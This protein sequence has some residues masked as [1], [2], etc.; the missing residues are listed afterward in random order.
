MKTLLQLRPLLITIGMFLG[1]TT[2]IA[3]Q[4]V[5]NGQLIDAETKESV[6]GATVV[7]KGSTIG[8]TTDF[9]GNFKLE[10]KE[11]G[12][13]VILF[14]Y[15]GYQTIEQD[16]E[17]GG[18]TDLGVIELL[19]DA[20]NLK[21]VNVIASVAVD[22]QTPVAVSTV[23][24]EIIEEK[25][26]NQEFPEVLKSSPGVFTTKQGGGFG[27]SRIT[28]R[29]FG[30]ENIAV[31]INGM[32]INDMENGAVYWSNWAGL[33]DVTRNMQVQRGL[34]ATKLAIPSVGG[35]INILTRTTDA[36]LG[37]NIMVAGGNNNYK[38]TSFT[39]STGLTEKKWAVTL[40]GSQSSGDGW[41]DGTNFEAYSYFANISK[42]FNANHS[43]ALSIFG[44]TQTHGQRRTQLPIETFEREGRRFNED[45]GYL[46]GQ[47]TNGRAN[48]YSKPVITLNHYW[49][50]SSSSQLAT[51][52]YA[53][54]GRGGG[55]GGYGA[56]QNF[57]TFRTGDGLIDFDRYY[58]ENQEDIAS[59][60]V[61]VASMN[62]HDWYGLLSNFTT[63]IS[64]KVTLTAGFDLR[65][66]EGR[67]FQEITNLLGGQF[68]YDIN[69]DVNEPIKI[70]R[71]G[72][73]VGFN[74]DGIVA[75]ESV[76]A[77]AEFVNDPIS[78]F[79]TVAF[80]N[81]SK[82]RVDFFNYMPGNR[83]SEWV[84]DQTISAKG[85]AN[86]NINDNHNVFF[87]TGFL[88][89]PPMFNAVFRNFKNDVND[90]AINEDIFT[91]EVGYGYR[92]T[93]VLANV[94]LYHTEWK[95]KS[96]I[97]AL[98]PDFQT[99]ANITGVDAR[100]QGIEADVEVILSPR[101][102][103]TGS[104]SVGD[105]IWTDDVESIFFDQSQQPIDTLQLFIKDLKVGN[106]AQT[107]VAAGAQ[108]EILSGLKLGVD[109]TFFSDLYADYDPSNR[110][111][112]EDR[113]QAWR[114]PKY[115]LFD[116]SASYKFRI[117][118]LDAYFNTKI[119]NIFDEK[120]I[121]DARDGIEHNQETAL[122]YYSVGTTW[123]V[124]LK[125]DF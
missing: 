17:L 30:S 108:Y 66:Y 77:Q 83:T 58:Q 76:F 44:A 9:D 3:A 89:R 100:H 31:T 45:W 61:L 110:T 56:D 37:G 105:W 122:V 70:A 94:N 33:S 78:A 59:N 125:V 97:V 120:Y 91:V 98:P 19:T 71:E 1:C 25:L 80:A 14:S 102:R 75:W 115:G 40:S 43:L 22:R 112:P 82:Q 57:R 29:G 87:N 109:Y 23:D 48:F 60:T 74:N 68:Y 104:L 20:V 73:K 28:L 53:S 26:G 69:K 90:D 93:N 39:V 7:I 123:S 16:I 54:F 92:S 12:P 119:N 99:F 11:T 101:A 62:D 21:E 51:T 106:A 103:I 63:S 121:A 86:Y 113:E 13:A 85:G 42:E 52:A 79:V 18:T 24:P 65:Y 46:F 32:P 124:S 27:D 35:T 95:N 111:D 67:H 41:V 10:T 96:L 84:H 88:Q 38:K 15:V 6:I 34:G 49:N 116:F 118:S 114:V 72:D 64:D 5:V 2:Y 47:Q 36:K 50:I 107:T 4:T 117:G 55:I 8:T 81:N